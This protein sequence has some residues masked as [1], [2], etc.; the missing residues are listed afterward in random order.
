MSDQDQMDMDG[1]N[2]EGEEDEKVPKYKNLTDEKIE[3]I[4]DMFEVFDKDKD[5]HISVFDFTNLLRWLD[6]NPTGREMEGYTEKYGKDNIDGLINL[7]AVKEVADRK[8]M[9]P[10]TIH[11][12]IESM[13]VLDTNNDGT[14]L[15]PELRWALTQLGD[16]MEQ[17]Q[18]DEMIKQI[19][20]GNKGFVEILEYANVCMPPPKEPK[21]KGK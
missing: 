6:F 2:V 14:I 17:T 9:E 19:D 18:V 8:M 11:E 20:D 1:N 15:V 7:G 12:V 16:A 3:D 21:G 5:G 4:E 13:K 10:D